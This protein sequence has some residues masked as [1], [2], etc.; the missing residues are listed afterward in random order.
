M[1]LLSPVTTIASLLSRKAVWSD[2]RATIDYQ[3]LLDGRVEE[4]KSDGPA[5]VFA[6]DELGKAFA[7]MAPG[8]PDLTLGFD[9]AFPTTDLPI[10]ISCAEPDALDQLLSRC[11]ESKLE[12]LVFLN[13]GDFLEPVL[14][15]YNCCRDR[16][17]QAVVYLALNE[18]GKVEEDRT[19]IGDDRMGVPKYAAE[20]SVTGKWSGHF[21]DRLNR[22]KF[23]CA[24]LF[25]RDWRRVML[26]RVAFEAAYHL[27]GVLHKGVPV[28]EVHEYFADEVDD[29]VYEMNRALRGHL[30]VQLLNGYEERMAA[31]G[32]A[33]FRSKVDN[34]LTS[35]SLKRAAHRNGLFYDIS[36]EMRRRDF[37][38]PTPMH[39]E[40]WEY[41]LDNRLFG[42]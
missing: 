35:I 10:Y 17:T 6:E 36:Q 22:H 5:V 24:E 33:H 7:R 29:M 13:Y 38:D 19:S 37:P 18:Y 14:K 34:K 21:A 28:K 32:Q 20:T 30:A 12:D 23:F 15:K 26:E 8:E 27:V 3:N 25:Y 42:P 40:Y 16:Q 4:R 11:P 1:F 9:S 39:T 31:Y 2:S 41:G